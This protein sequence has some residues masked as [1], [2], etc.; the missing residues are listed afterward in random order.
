MRGGVGGWFLNRPATS[1]LMEKAARWKIEKRGEKKREL[2][3]ADTF[4][5]P[6]LAL[7]FWA[8]VVVCAG[9][10]MT[11]ANYCCHFIKGIRLARAEKALTG[12]C[13]EK[14]TGNRAPDKRAGRFPRNCDVWKGEEGRGRGKGRGETKER[15]KR[16]IMKRQKAVTGFLHILT[17]GFPGL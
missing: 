13:G 12:M 4:G 10:G 16:D 6:P 1:G 5:P 14:A 8:A 17:S 15:R 9:T 2:E 3:P 11:K 7:Y